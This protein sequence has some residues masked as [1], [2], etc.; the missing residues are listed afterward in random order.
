MKTLLLSL[1]LGTIAMP[2]LTLRAEDEKKEEAAADSGA[3]LDQVK[4]GEVFANGPVTMDDLK[5]KVVVVE[6]WGVH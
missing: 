6:L 3:T 4:L 2:A 5:G 1:L